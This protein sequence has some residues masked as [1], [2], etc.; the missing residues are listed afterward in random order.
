L[1]PPEQIIRLGITHTAAVVVE[2]ELLARNLSV[3]ML[4]DL[5]RTR[6]DGP[7]AGPQLAG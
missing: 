4:A 6:L 5:L 1:I 7:R 3:D 2:G